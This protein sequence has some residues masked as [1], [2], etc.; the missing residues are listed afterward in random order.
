[1]NSIKRNLIKLLLFIFIFSN[2]I[3]S[4]NA[5][6][7]VSALHKVFVSDDIISTFAPDLDPPVLYSILVD[8]KVVSLTTK[9]KVMANVVYYGSGTSSCIIYYRKPMSGNTYFIWPESNPYSGFFEKSIDINEF[10]EYG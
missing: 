1:M 9:L 3:I 4:V 7:I 8:K 6:T 2:N 5:T 10:S